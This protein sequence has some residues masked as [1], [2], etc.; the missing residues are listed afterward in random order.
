MGFSLR[1]AV[2]SVGDGI[3]H[4]V[5][6]VKKKAGEIID[7][8]AHIVG[9][10]LEHVGLDDAADWVED[11]GDHIADDLGAHVAEQQLG[12]SEEPDELLHGDPAKIRE[13][14]LHLAK[15]S[16]AFDT[17]HTG[18]AH[19]DPGDWDG[20]GAEAFRAKFKTQPAKWA[21]AATACAQAGL[22]LKTY[23]ETVDWAKGQAKEAVR[24]WKCL[25]VNCRR[26]P[27]KVRNSC[28]PP[29]LESDAAGATK[30]AR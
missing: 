7:D 18:L 20:T 10:G 1:K 5:D 23:A 2:N 30:A 9:D 24:L 26:T 8:G 27:A 6:K 19:L 29:L 4:G 3:E 16:L 22:A 13:A 15:L 12:Q 14:V 25:S 11:H 28:R 17:G 21:H